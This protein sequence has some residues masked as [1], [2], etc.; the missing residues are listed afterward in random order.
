MTG[1]ITALPTAELEA[2]RL[3]HMA[4]ERYAAKLEARL[5]HVRC[6]ARLIEDADVRSL[7]QEL[8]FV[9]DERK[10]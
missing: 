5:E 6:A 4:A 9:K 8:T 2:A 10:A 1:P 3:S 7:V